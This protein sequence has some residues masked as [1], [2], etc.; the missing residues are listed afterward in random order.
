MAKFILLKSQIPIEQLQ[1]LI[2][3]CFCCQ[4]LKKAEKDF[5]FIKLSPHSF[6]EDTFFFI[7]IFGSNP[8]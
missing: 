8:K 4:M 3:Y 7:K 2:V 5:L 6:C 1:Y